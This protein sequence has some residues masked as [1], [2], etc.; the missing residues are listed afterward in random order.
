MNNRADAFKKK[1]LQYERAANVATDPE[2]CRMYLDL[3]CQL[4]AKAEQVEAFE[5]A[6]ALRQG[7]WW[8]EAGSRE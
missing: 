3:A 7:I 2:A 8:S 6:G 4:R 5:R 1:A